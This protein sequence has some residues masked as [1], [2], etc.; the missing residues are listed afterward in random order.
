MFIQDFQSTYCHIYHLELI[1]V[2]LIQC[3][4]N[5]SPLFAYIFDTLR[6]SREFNNILIFSCYLY[7]IISCF[8]AWLNMGFTLSINECLLI[9]IFIIHY[10]HSRLAL[11]SHCQHS[12]L[13]KAAPY[14]RI[15]S[16]RSCPTGTR[17]G[18][19]TYSY[20]FAYSN[21]CK[22]PRQRIDQWVYQG[23]LAR[24][25]PFPRCH[26]EQR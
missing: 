4:L 24:P 19:R 11:I 20:S 17:T 1:L 25:K 9:H 8:I 5:V 18:I 10:L 26:P 13:A 15:P 22:A 3:F 16:H 12:D 23:A 21:E 7:L 14:L 2:K 6:L